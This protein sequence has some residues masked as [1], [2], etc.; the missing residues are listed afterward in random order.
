M[1]AK[2]ALYQLGA[3]CSS[4]GG[5]GSLGFGYDP[6]YKGGFNSNDNYKPDLG[7]YNFDK[8]KIPAIPSK[9]DRTFELINK[10]TGQVFNVLNHGLNFAERFG[11]I[12]T[13]GSQVAVRDK[14]T[15]EER[16]LSEAEKQHIYQ[17]GLQMA[18]NP[19]GQSSNAFSDLLMAKFLTENKGNSSNTSLYIGLAV[20]GVVLITMMM[21]MMNKK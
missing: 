9:T 6:K 19:Q 1:E 8:Q 7:N 12:Q 2:L 13:P 15:G 5:L 18:Q 21:L 11:W 14:K 16:T 4:C 10:R 3:P 17:Q 20:G